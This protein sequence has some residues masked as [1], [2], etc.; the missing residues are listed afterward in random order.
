[1]KSLRIIFFNLI[2]FIIFYCTSF[3]DGINDD[4]EKSHEF[5]REAFTEGFPWELIKVIRP[6]PPKILFSWRH[7]A[8]FTGQFQ[9]RPG[10]GE[11]IELYGLCEAT[12]N[13]DLKIE[14][15]EVN[16]HKKILGYSG[17]FLRILL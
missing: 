4:F 17:Y 6:D 13:E 7:W 12:V 15:L 16:I 10:K 1:M 14:S 11:L 8:K 2:F 5:F 3:S 9:G